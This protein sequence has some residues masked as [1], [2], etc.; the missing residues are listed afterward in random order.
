MI[1]FVRRSDHVVYLFVLLHDETESAAYLRR[2]SVPMH[3]LGQASF[4]KLHI[5]SHT[6]DGE[7]QSCF[8]APTCAGMM[9]TLHRRQPS[10]SPTFGRRRNRVWHKS[11]II[12]YTKYYYYHNISQA[13]S[14]NVQEKRWELIHTS[15][16]VHCKSE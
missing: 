1:C 9:F 15:T 13:I 12:H 5:A 6:I 10:E 2:I 7:G 3:F 16:V 11:A 14:A 8:A 4:F